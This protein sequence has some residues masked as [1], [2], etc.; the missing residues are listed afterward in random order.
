MP[1]IR[2]RSTV[3]HPSLRVRWRWMGA[4]AFLMLCSASVWGAGLF[5]IMLVMLIAWILWRSDRDNGPH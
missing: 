5:P 4:V 3:P 2:P 1:A